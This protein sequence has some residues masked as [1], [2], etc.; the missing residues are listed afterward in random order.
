MAWGCASASAAD[1]TITF[2]AGAAA[3]AYMPANVSINAG[4]TVTFNGGFANHPLVWDAGTFPTQATGTSKAYTFASS[5]LYRFHCSIHDSM[6]GSVDVNALAT[7]DFTFAPAQPQTGQAVTFTATAFRDPD[8]S[9]ARYEW[10]LDGDG[11]FEASGQPVSHTYTAAGIVTAALRYVDDRNETS[12][13]TTHG[14]TV[15]R[16]AGGGSGGGAT[17]PPGQPGGPGSSAPIQPGALG[18]P[19]SPDGGAQGAGPSGAETKAPRLRIGVRAL[20]FTAGKARVAI[21]VGRASALKATLRRGR[22]TLATGTATVKRAGAV[23]ITL[24][25]TRAGSGAL[26]RAHG[27]MRASLTVVARP[28]TGGT[29][30]TVT[31][32]LSVRR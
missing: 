20:T 13:A 22:T 15:V 18:S 3:G 21:T 4:N 1:Q 24:R 8:G 30:A 14:F 17:P 25:L 7:P 32:V 2:P 5:G 29:A 28:R 12:S 11:T 23:S 19:S 26:R 16:G 9:I 27:R 10:D 6:V 31:K